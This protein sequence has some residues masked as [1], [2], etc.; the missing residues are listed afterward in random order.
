M[1][2][3]FPEHNDASSDMTAG[4]IAKSA[5]HEAA[6]EA[7]RIAMDKLADHVGIK[8]SS[9]GQEQKVAWQKPKD[10]AYME[11]SGRVL[12]DLPET[13]KAYAQDEAGRMAII[14]ME[15]AELLKAQTP[16]EISHELVHLG[17]ATLHLWRL[18]NNA[19]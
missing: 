8:T 2:I 4:G 16:E 17:S 19:E 15:Y 11:Q 12:R 9:A 13:W 10:W 5:A 3:L 14:K 1:L 6:R 18:L 7:A